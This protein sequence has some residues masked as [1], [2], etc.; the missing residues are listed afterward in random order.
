M[1]PWEVD[2]D[3]PPRVLTLGET[4]LGLEHFGWDWWHATQLQHLT[5]DG[6]PDGPPR[7][8]LLWVIRGAPGQL[9]AL[10]KDLD[11]ATRLYEKELLAIADARRKPCGLLWRVAPAPPPSFEEAEQSLRE[12]RVDLWLA[13]LRREGR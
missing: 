4:L 13:E 12:F 2:P 11:F 8:G 1:R 5:H 9:P 3:G 7:D 6:E 10:P